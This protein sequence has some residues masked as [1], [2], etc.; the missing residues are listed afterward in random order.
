MMPS[1]LKY[2]TIVGAV[3]FA[4]LIGLN[5]LMD[6]GGPGPTLVK[7]EAR[8]PVIQLDPRASKV[9]RLRAEEAAQK[10][11]SAAPI[12]TAA[13]AQ[14]APV[15]QPVAAAAAPQPV[16]AAVQPAE[17]AQ[18]IAPAA[19]AT[20]PDEGGAERAVR[21]AQQ[22]MKAEKARKQRIARE[23]AKARALEEASAQ[24]VPQYQQQ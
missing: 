23:R 13:L 17:P 4:G 11:A 22:K 3:L 10:A 14:P 7:A 21:A 20:G 15:E 18:T 5:A 24:Q 16:T 2:F 9:E 8:K 19:L 6:P 1:L 12:A